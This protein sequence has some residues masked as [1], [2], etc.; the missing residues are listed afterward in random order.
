MT[1]RTDIIQHLIDTNNFKSYLEIGVEHGTNFQTIQCDNKVGVDP[2]PES[3][4]TIH[5]TSDD[6]F[7]TNTQTW[8]LI[9]IDGLHHKDQVLKDMKNALKSLS[10]NGFI[11]VHDVS[12]EDEAMQIVPRM[13]GIWTGDVWKA[14]LTLRKTRK[15]ISMYC[16]DTDYGCGI[17]RKGRQELVNTGGL[18]ATYKNL[19]ENRKEWLNLIPVA[20]FYELFS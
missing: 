10:S 6:F 1:L 15:T 8:D 2:D 19:T 13:Q 3:K 11:V 5:E 20:K 12:P 16:V 4:A 14:W 17:I 18:R 9:F 7:R